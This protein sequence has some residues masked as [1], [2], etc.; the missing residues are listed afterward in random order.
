[1]TL[2][3]DN[4]KPFRGNNRAPMKS[5]TTIIVVIVA[6]LILGFAITVAIVSGKSFF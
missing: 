6:A 5:R 4:N 1:M 3:K 2:D